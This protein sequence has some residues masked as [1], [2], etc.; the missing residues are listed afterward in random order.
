MLD[1]VVLV[2]G[3]GTL[4]QAL[5]D[6]VASGGAPYRL[7]GVGSDRTD[8]AGLARARAARLETFVVD[9]AAHKQRS[10]SSR[11]LANPS[12]SSNTPF[13]RNASRMQP[14]KR[15]PIF[16]IT[17]ADSWLRPKHWLPTRCKPNSAKPKS[18]TARAASAP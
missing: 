6:D 5:I 18:I 8:L 13:L 12:K 1:V 2:S 4:L 9:V 7:V 3:S 15:R 14:S 16:S 11:T 17:R 10:Q